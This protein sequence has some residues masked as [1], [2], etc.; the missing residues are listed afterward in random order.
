MLKVNITGLSVVLT[1]CIFSLVLSVVLTFV[2]FSLVL[3]VALVVYVSGFFITVSKES[4]KLVSDFCAQN[5]RIYCQNLSAPF[6]VQVN[7]RSF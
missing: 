6:I 3:S 7:P 2:F 1:F 4:I 5:D